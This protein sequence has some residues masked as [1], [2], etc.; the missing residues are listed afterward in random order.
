V[1]EKGLL[2]SLRKK[3]KPE[4]LFG[5]AVVTSSD[6]G[7]EFISLG[8]ISLLLM[9]DD[10]FSSWTDAIHLGVKGKA[11]SFHFTKSLFIEGAKD[12]LSLIP[13]VKLVPYILKLDS[14]FSFSHE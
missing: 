9:G 14:S 3:W 11:D 10:G 7:L 13:L 2:E 4:E 12:T 5:T 1:R 8:L 6:G